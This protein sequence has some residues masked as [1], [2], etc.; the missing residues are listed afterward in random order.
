MAKAAEPLG[1]LADRLWR[2][3]GRAEVPPLFSGSAEAR[4]HNPAV[5]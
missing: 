5:P 3:L 1:K 4:R 2:C